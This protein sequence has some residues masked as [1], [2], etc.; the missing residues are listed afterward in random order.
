MPQDGCGKSVARVEAWFFQVLHDVVERWQANPYFYSHVGPC[1]LL[2][3][4]MFTTPEAVLQL[5]ELA[6]LRYPFSR[7]CC[8]TLWI[9]ASRK[10][11]EES[12]RSSIALRVNEGVIEWLNAVG[13]FEKACRLYKGRGT[14]TRYLL[15]LCT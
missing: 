4:S 1:C 12:T 14:K 2:I 5:D 15:Q 13:N 3:T 6:E 9:T 8:F 7:S 10:H 11:F